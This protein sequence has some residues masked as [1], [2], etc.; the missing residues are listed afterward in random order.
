MNPKGSEFATLIPVLGG[1]MK[2]NYDQGRRPLLLLFS[3]A[4]QDHDE[5]KS[6]IR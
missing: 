1:G 3:V 5:R 4:C 2:E 6:K